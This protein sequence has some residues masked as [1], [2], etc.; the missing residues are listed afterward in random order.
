MFEGNRYTPAL[1]E[2]VVFSSTRHQGKVEVIPH[3][4]PYD[5][6]KQLRVE[7]REKFKKHRPSSIGQAMRI[8]GITPSAI[9]LLAV[10]LKRF[11][12]GELAGS[13]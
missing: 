10:Y 13:R 5:E 11:R 4:F 1:F 12:A 7:A 6:I 2:V 9:S 3:D 8:P